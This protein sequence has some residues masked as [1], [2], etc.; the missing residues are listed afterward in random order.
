MI[1]TPM[2]AGG[3]SGGPVDTPGA[4]YTPVVLPGV[5][6]WAT[7]APSTAEPQQIAPRPHR[8]PLNAYIPSQP[9]A[10]SAVASSRMADDC[11]CDTSRPLRWYEVVSAVAIIIIAVSAL[12]KL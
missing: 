2:A 9:S 5:T 8:V 12:R 1:A 3:I 11:G 6:P 4:M 10:A 7:P